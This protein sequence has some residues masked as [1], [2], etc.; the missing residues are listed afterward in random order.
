MQADM[1]L[2]V[3]QKWI[4]LKRQI[5]KS[6]KS[7]KYK[8][9]DILPGEYDLCKQNGVSR[10]TVRQA[11][12]ALQNEGVVERLP[13]RGTFV[14]DANE[15]TVNQVGAC[16]DSRLSCNPFVLVI[17]E[18]SRPIFSVLA[19]GFDDFLNSYNQQ[20]MICHSLNDIYRQ[21]DI[22]LRLLS[23]NVSGV[24]LVP[25]IA[26]VTPVH[27]ILQLQNNNVPIVLCHRRVPDVS[28]PLICWDSD[29]IGK[30][31]AEEIVKHGHKNVAY[32][33][34]F[35]Y[36]IN[37]E[38]LAGFTAV[39]N[40][41]GIELPQEN[42]LWGEKPAEGKSG[43]GVSEELL[44]RLL[45]SNNRPTAIFC[46]DT[47]EAEKLYMVALQCGLK[48]PKDIS[49]VSSDDKQ[50]TSYISNK[51]ALVLKNEL[52]L[53]LEAAK[54]LYQMKQR[55][56]SLTDNRVIKVGLEFAEGRSLASL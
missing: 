54:L 51:L 34:L 7:G 27:Q 28:T 44:A 35:K 38:Q 36:S 25:P 55:K 52:E 29:A 10:T 18:I 5:S 37:E 24:A 33:G 45:L 22:I 42:I 21:G 20:M 23:Q 14:R 47:L 15:V 2:N 41:A 3:N 8:P 32:I 9:G 11:L 30:M 43:G 50:H 49:I 46:S 53:G 1:E 12:G 31:A 19:K 39:L 13:G 26:T 6:I 4:C 56:V 17:P 40:G 16:E 48:I